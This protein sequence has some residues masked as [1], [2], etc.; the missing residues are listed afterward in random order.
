MPREVPLYTL[1][2][3]PLLFCTTIILNVRCVSSFS[4]NCLELVEFD[5]DEIENHLSKLNLTD[6]P[7]VKMMTAGFKCPISALP[8]G[9]L[10]SDW[11]RLLL[12]QEAQPDGSIIKSK[13]IRLMRILIVAYFQMEERFDDVI[14]SD[15]AIPKK[16]SRETLVTVSNTDDKNKLYSSNIDYLR[17]TETSNYD[18]NS[19][20]Y[21]TLTDKNDNMEIK[22]S[23]IAEIVV[24][25]N[26][27]NETTTIVPFNVTHENVTSSTDLN[28]TITAPFSSG[29]FDVKKAS[30]KIIAI[31]NCLKQPFKDIVR[32]NQNRK[33]SK[34]YETLK[35]KAKHTERAA[36]ND[37]KINY[38]KNRTRITPPPNEF[39]QHVTFPPVNVSTSAR[40]HQMG[41]N[42][43]KASGQKSR[44]KTRELEKLYENYG[45][46][47]WR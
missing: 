19:Y 21:S 18:V 16:P 5:V 44:A 33:R 24:A 28:V 3:V 31:D 35:N 11:S 39:W 42:G 9:A 20:T 17:T 7:T 45:R 6:V 30:S 26:S 34:V 38:K 40:T 37:N 4:D 13:L 32:K 43:F 36:Q 1:L 15:T 10:K 14:S 46:F 2:Y 47:L 29:A 22:L 41:L 8:F 23:S 12:L 25:R 27:S